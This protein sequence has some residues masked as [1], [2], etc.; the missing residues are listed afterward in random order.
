MA[1]LPLDQGLM[2]LQGRARA[3]R[4]LLWAFIG[5]VAVMASAWLGVDALGAG[6]CPPELL[7]LAG[8]ASVAVVALIILCTVIVGMWIYRAHANLFAA[9][10]DGLEFKPG[11]SVGWFF[12][13][14]AGL[15]KPFQAMRE[16]WNASH[17]S[18]DGYTSHVDPT[19]S[20]WW[21]LWIAGNVVVNIS[22]RL[23]GPGSGIGMFDMLGFVLF[24]A[25]AWFML[26]I[27]ERVTEAQ[28]SGL[29]AVYAFA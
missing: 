25:A 1:E 6:R 5:G 22:T 11:W 29:G 28:T 3:A 14:I 4:F 19:L 8:L 16:L 7:R 27:V 17:L 26:R 9:G 23:R 24:A 2:V 15:F 13:P 10:V 12:V 20:I 21:G 18:E